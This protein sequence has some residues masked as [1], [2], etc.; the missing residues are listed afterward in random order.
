MLIL[1]LDEDAVV[2]ASV[3][4]GAR[5]VFAEMHHFDGRYDLVSFLTEA[6][7]TAYGL[8]ATLT[9]YGHLVEHEHREFVLMEGD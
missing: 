4:T 9:Q 1:L 2:V 7:M 3:T 5:T 6:E 8:A